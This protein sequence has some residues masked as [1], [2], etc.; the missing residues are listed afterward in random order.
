MPE[1][2]EKPRLLVF[3]VAFNAERTIEKTLRRLPAT[4]GDRYQVEILAIDDCS[5]DKTF[6]QGEAMRRAN[7]LPFKLTMLFNPVNLGYGGNQ[8]VGFHYAIENKFD[9]VA[10]VHGD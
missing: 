5:T 6:E 2:S 3:I 7:S 1:S 9:F 8:K 4:L 10:L